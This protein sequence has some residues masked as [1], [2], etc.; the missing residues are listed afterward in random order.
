[1]IKFR[2]QTIPRRPLHPCTETGQFKSEERYFF[3]PKKSHIIHE[4]I[5]I[6]SM[7]WTNNGNQKKNNNKIW[8]FSPKSMILSIS[9]K[10]ISQK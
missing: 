9:D 6:T 7:N 1:M 10:K 3:R 5:T 2:R 8:G 4:N